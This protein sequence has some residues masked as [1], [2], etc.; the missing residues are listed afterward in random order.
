MQHIT[1]VFNHRQLHTQTDTQI[2]H[3]VFAG[4][5]DG[6]HFTSGTALTKTTWYQNRIG[7]V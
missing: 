6:S 3:F 7:I 5:S 2:R 1:G 4:V